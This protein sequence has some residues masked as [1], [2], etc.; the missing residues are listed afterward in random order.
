MN[1]T[2]IEA[3]TSSG[4]DDWETPAWLFDQ[5]NDEF[6]FTL[7][8][9]CTH[10]T[11]KCHKHYTP[12]ENGLLQDWGGRS[13]FAIRPTPEKPVPIP[14]KSLGCRNAPQRRKSPAPLWWPCCQPER[15]QNFSTATFTARLKF[16]SSKAGCHSL[17]TAKRQASRCL[18][19]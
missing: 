11:A 10:K 3:M 12:E 16:V 7:D 2:T 9:C 1:K 19:Q 15:T 13:S 4:K 17:T 5:L 6:H 8:P 18:A 14:G